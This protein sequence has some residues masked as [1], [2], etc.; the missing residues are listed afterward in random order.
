MENWYNMDK[1]AVL[2]EYHSDAEKGL[3]GSEAEARQARFGLNKFAEKKKEGLCSQ[4]I[5]QLKDVAVIILLLAAFLSFA[6][7][8]RDGHGFIE[9]AVIISVVIMN[10]I[11]AL[12]Q[13]RGAEKALEAL[14]VLNSPS[15]FVV[16]DGYKQEIDTTL[17]VPGDII[18]LK[19]GDLVPADARLLSCEG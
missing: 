12:T 8:L 13:E 11:L 3:T 5:R 1:G 10:L 14:S 16:R 15:C 9:P 7:A 17:V 19:T 2:K 6:L 4:I 18:V